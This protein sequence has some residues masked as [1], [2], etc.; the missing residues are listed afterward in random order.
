MNVM[1]AQAQEC[2]LE[3]SIIDGRK[4]NINTKV[5]AQCIDYYKLALTNLEKPNV[6]SLMGS[7]KAKEFKQYIQ[8]KSSY[9]AAL[10]HY[11]GALNSS[12]LKKHGEAVSFI[13]QAE[14]KIGE[15]V[16]QKYLKEFQETLKHAQEVIETKAK[17]LRK[18]NDFVYNEKIPDAASLPETKGVGVFLLNLKASNI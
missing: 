9:Y 2:V 13:Q 6:T 17:Q 15:C 16:K 7:R 18:D 4:P 3:K 8:F 10:L 5:I 11:Y 1:L 14:A 12:E